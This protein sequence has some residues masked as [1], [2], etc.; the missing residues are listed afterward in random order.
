MTLLKCARVQRKIPMNR[1]MAFPTRLHVWPAKTQI[2]LCIRGF[3]GHSVGS[4]WS[5]A[6][7]SVQQRLRS[8]C[9]SVQAD[10]SL[11]WACMQICM[12]CYALAQSNVICKW[13]RTNPAYTILDIIYLLENSSVWCLMHEKGCNATCQPREN[14]EQLASTKFDQI[15]LCSPI[16]STGSSDAVNALLTLVLL[17]WI[18][19]A[20]DKALFASEKCWYLFYFSTKTYVVGTH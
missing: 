17:N 11:C 16:Q 9:T 3:A 18:C 5:K 15:L 1:G 6:S 7:S 19:I 20:T 4:Q 10:L 2:S 14:P 8:A 12:K 13:Q